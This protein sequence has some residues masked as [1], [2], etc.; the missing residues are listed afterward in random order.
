MWSD[1][2][3]LYFSFSKTC[4]HIKHAGKP[5]KHQVKSPNSAKI[6]QAEFSNQLQH[7]ASTG[8]LKRWG[9]YQKIKL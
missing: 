4:N 2:F 6:P 9:G 5:Q 1:L 8:T 3:P 7:I